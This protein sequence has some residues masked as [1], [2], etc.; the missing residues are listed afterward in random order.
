[1]ADTVSPFRLA[2]VEHKADYRANL[3]FCCDHYR[4]VS[5]VCRRLRI[6]RQQFNRYLT[7]S[8]IPSRH[9]HK[10]V[11]DFF[12]LEEGELFTPHAAFAATFKR[13]IK[14]QDSPAV[15][16]HHAGL[17]RAISGANAAN[18]SDYQGFYFK[19][20]YTYLGAW[21][22]K[23]E[24]AHWYY[25]GD[26]LVSSVKQRYMG[27]DETED[28]ALRFI[29]YRGVVGQVG[30]RLLVVDHHRGT[31]REVSTMVLY[32]KARLLRRLHGLTLGVSHGPARLIGAARV[33]MD[34]LGTEIDIRAALNRLGTF[35][36]NELSVPE[37]VKRAVRNDMRDDETLFVA[38]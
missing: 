33:V 19:Y 26:A 9:N 34:F 4:S 16:R 21:R 28:A 17:L 11:S 30:D 29:T 7:G 22:I 18:L 12:G 32:P 15:L 31:S 14:A 37:A 13:R 6:N 5:E 24:L 36:L 35:D 25:D 8:A 2:F 20:F 1:M 10:L 23:R 3:Q 27:E 38:R